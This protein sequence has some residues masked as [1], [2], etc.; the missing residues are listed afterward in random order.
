LALRKRLNASWTSA[1]VQGLAAFDFF[2][3]GFGADVAA[4]LAAGRLWDFWMR[5]GDVGLFLGSGLRVI[6]AMIGIY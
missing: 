5:L 1:G 2:A 4:D 3:A 6:F